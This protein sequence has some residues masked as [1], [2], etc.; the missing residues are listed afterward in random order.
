ME[1]HTFI[2]GK[3]GI[4]LTQS[5][6]KAKPIMH[7]TPDKSLNKKFMTLDIETIPSSLTQDGNQTPYLITAYD[8]TNT[9]VEYA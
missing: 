3:D 1:T 7:K 4:L 8:G 6:L 5:N 9:L 2:V